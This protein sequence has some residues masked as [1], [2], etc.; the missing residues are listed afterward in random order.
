MPAEL[1]RDLEQEPAGI[2]R[3]LL[4]SQI[5]NRRKILWCGDE[6]LPDL[7]NEIHQLT[8]GKFLSRTYRIIAG[9]QPIMLINEKFP[10]P[11]GTL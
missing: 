7:P 11:E 1:L 8:G 3:A 4:N 5:E 10:I 6:Q 2:G 9:G